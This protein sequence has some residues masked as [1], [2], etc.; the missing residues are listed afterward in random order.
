VD[1]ILLARLLERNQILQI[2]YTDDESVN[3]ATDEYLDDETEYS[4]RKG[5]PVI[6]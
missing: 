3:E 5:P 1:E 4:A 6:L 2:T